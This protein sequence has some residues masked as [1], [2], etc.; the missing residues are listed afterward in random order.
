[1]TRLVQIA[2]VTSGAL[3]VV[4]V[5]V[6]FW[7]KDASPVT[8]PGPNQVQTGLATPYVPSESGELLPRP[9]PPKHEVPGK[10]APNPY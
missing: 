10:I 8:P 5:T 6:S 7:P 9:I 3:L 2:S 4:A 1:M